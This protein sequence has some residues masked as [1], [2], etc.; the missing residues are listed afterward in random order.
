MYHTEQY[1]TEQYSRS[2]SQDASNKNRCA[3]YGCPL[4]G[5]VS[6]HSG[7]NSTYYCRYHAQSTADKFQAL[8]YRLNQNLDLIQHLQMIE[9]IMTFPHFFT[10]GDLAEKRDRLFAFKTMPKNSEETYDDYFIRLKKFVAETITP[11]LIW[12]P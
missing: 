6:Y 8:T 7:A 11:Q 2:N 5:S 12:R 9:S 3:A 1:H 10:G 4:P